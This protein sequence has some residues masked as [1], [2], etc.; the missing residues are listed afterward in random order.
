MTASRSSSLRSNSFETTPHR[1]A[2]LMLK[3]PGRN[4][5]ISSALLLNVV[6]LS[7]A[8]CT[9]QS[10]H[11]IISSSDKTSTVDAARAYDHLKKLVAFGPHPSGSEAI[12]QTQAYLEGELKSYG[13]NVSE[14]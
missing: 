10:N 12:K 5:R 14:D 6:L 7:P 13:L 2:H 8:A 9:A 4:W 3:K 11:E 1:E